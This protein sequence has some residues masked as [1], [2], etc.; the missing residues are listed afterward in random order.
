MHSDM[1]FLHF[2]PS[3]LAY[4]G[5]VD[6]YGYIDQ[7]FSQ[8]VKELGWFYYPPLTY[9]TL[10][11]F[12]FL[13]RPL[14]S[15]FDQWLLLSY[16]GVDVPNLPTY[17]FLP[18]GQHSFSYILMMKIPYLFFDIFAG[19]FLL[20]IPDKPQKALTAFKYWMLNPV[21]LYSCF[22]FGQFD[23][24]PAF[25]IILSI[26]FA[27][28]EKPY[29]SV[30]MLGIGGGYKLV[31]MLLLPIASV[32]LGKTHIERIKLFL[33][34]LIIFIIPIMLL[35]LPSHGAVVKSIFPAIL[36]VGMGVNKNLLILIL[37]AMFIVGYLG[38]LAHAYFHSKKQ[39]AH[40]CNLLQKY[41]LIILLLFFVSMAS[42]SFH[43]LVVL[44]PIL[45]LEIAQDQK[46]RKW[47]LILILSFIPL[48]ITG[49]LLWA[50]LLEPLH[51]TLFLSLPSF[52][53]IIN[54]IVPYAY[55]RAGAK[56]VLIITSLWIVFQ[57]IHCMFTKN[58]DCTKQ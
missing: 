2:F 46:M 15:G 57:S 30:I 13:F 44:T 38:I 4:Q 10:G 43:Y 16:I 42:P 18:A 9:F 35:W 58:I 17:L 12:Q 41:Y 6:P 3:L 49:R 22:I 56:S 51:P 36:T 20:R 1:S 40:P 19:F 50:G 8:S 55:I 24:I 21:V 47:I 54:L 39:Q 23:V 28:R 5:I 34:G 37:Q 7:H 48:T 14:V 32:F 33:L 31:P 25:F 27:K 11:F 52:D 53:Q 45:A 26:I 29:L